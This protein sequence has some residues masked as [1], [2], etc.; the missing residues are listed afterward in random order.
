MSKGARW[1]ITDR[2]NVKGRFRETLE[3]IKKVFVDLFCL[4]VGG[5]VLDFSVI[6][7]SLYFGLKA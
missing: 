4:K 2:V 1:Y 5:A 3:R 6:T 7:F